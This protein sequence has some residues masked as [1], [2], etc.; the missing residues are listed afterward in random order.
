M[1]GTTE[2]MMKVHVETF[3]KNTMGKNKNESTL[4]SM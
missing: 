3:W 4:L 1:G 2:T